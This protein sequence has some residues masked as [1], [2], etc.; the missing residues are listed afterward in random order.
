[1]KLMRA[2]VHRVFGFFC[3]LLAMSCSAKDADG[4]GF[5]SDVDCNDLD[6]SIPPAAEE[7]CDS[8][9]NDCNLKV[10]DG[11]DSTWYLAAENS[12]SSLSCV[13]DFSVE[14]NDLSEANLYSLL[15]QLSGC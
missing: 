15:V 5:T 13:A 10:D 1:M 8:I 3:L 6:S 7:V 2:F 12:L 11:L 4:D 9:D 14:D